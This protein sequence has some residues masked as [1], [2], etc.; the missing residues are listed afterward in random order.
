MKLLDGWGTQSF[1]QPWAG[2]AGGRLIQGLDVLGELLDRFQGDRWTGWNRSIDPLA[3]FA[4]ANQP[5]FGSW[6]VETSATIDW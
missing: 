1:I 2:F 6:T 5:A 3:F 4:A